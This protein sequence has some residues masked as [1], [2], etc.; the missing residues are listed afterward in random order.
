MKTDNYEIISNGELWRLVAAM[1][2]P[3]WRCAI[4]KLLRWTCWAIDHWWCRLLGSSVVYIEHVIEGECSLVRR[5]LVAESGTAVGL[6][7]LDWAPFFTALRRN[8]WTLLVRRSVKDHCIPFFAISFTFLLSWNWHHYYVLQ[9]SVFWYLKR[10]YFRSI[11][12][13]L[14]IFSWDS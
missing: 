5:A 12:K 9:T 3:Y 4:S 1:W 8:P 11:W 2:D 13:V 7:I 6:K 10:T 14:L